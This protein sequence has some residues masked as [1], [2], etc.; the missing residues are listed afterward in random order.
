[1]NLQV[2]LGL[3]FGTLTFLLIVSAILS[4]VLVR[5]I[6]SDVQNLGR[7]V[8]PLQEAVLEMQI[9]VGESNKSIIQYSIDRDDSRIRKFLE[10]KIDFELALEEYNRLAE[11]EAEIA[12]GRRVGQIH[13]GFG[14]ISDDIIGVTNNL[15]ASMIRLNQDVANIDRILNDQLE[16]LIDRDA[17]DGLSKLEA[18]LNMGIRVNKSFLAVQSYLA[19]PEPQLRETVREEQEGFRQFQAI[20]RANPLSL[21]EEVIVGVVDD[22]FIDTVALSQ[23]IMDQAD[24]QRVLLVSLAGGLEQIDRIVNED[25]QPL[26]VAET[27]EALTGAESSVDGATLSVFILIA[28]GIVVGIGTALIVG[29]Q[30]VNPI[31]RLTNVAGELGEGNLAVRANAETNDEIGSLANSFNQM[32][33]ARQQAESQR[34][35]LIAELA[36]QNAELAQ[37][38][39]LKDNFLSSVS[40]ELRTPLTAIKGSAELLLDDEDVTEEVSKQ[41]LTIINIESDRL[42]RLIND[43]LD[44]ARYESGQEVWNDG[45]NPVREIVESAISGV[46]SLAI[47][48]SLNISLDLETELSEVWCDPDK[49]NQVLT[50]LLS[51]A[52]KFTPDN[53]EIG[54]SVTES[55]EAGDPLE[56][57][58]VEVKVSDNGIGIPRDELD[59]IFE[60]FKQVG[61]APSD[62][63]KGTGLGLPICKEI[64]DHYGGK[65]WAESVL[66]KGSVFTFNI[67]VEQR[68]PAGE[69]EAADSSDSSVT[70]SG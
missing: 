67:P 32:A 57:R 15:Q 46:Q 53:G 37:L 48:K 55:L 68:M 8:A 17:P 44:L 35:A 6:D 18:V 69:P 20:F 56:G 61:D 60:K 45:P 49:I 38:D 25:V 50:N 70:A 11:T 7:V 12:A 21:S 19:N 13:G 42:T 66:G 4:Y 41:F 36:R 10:T 54:I 2:K 29:R 9:S 43:V 23:R 5:R 34:V 31:V 26:I 14:E 22:V 1:M 28:M 64:V 33:A 30:I 58:I 39:E 16:V 62:V 63:Q 65:I 40:H 24:E 3:L 52:I 51:N 47:Q 27:G 59:E